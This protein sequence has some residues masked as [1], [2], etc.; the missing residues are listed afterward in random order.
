MSARA[1]MSIHLRSVQ[2]KGELVYVATV[3]TGFASAVFT[4]ADRM[5]AFKQASEWAFGRLQ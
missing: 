4:S 1:E 5:D 3:V 2:V